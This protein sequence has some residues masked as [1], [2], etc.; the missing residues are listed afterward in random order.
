MSK[1]ISAKNISEAIGTLIAKLCYRAADE[2]GDGFAEKTSEWRSNNALEILKR[3]DNKYQKISISGN[4]HAHPRLVHHILEEGSWN[5]SDHVQNMWAGLLASSCTESGDDESNLVF[6]N[7]LKQLTSIEAVVV[8]Y[9]C[10]K[11]VKSITR[12]GWIW[13]E[14]LTIELEELVKLTGISDFHRLDR[15]LDHLRSLELIQGGFDPMSTAAN[16]TPSA[17]AIQMYVRCQGYIGSP[18]E[19]FGL[20]ENEDS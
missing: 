11:C 6:V 14:H 13:G 15:E 19:Y 2:L 17:L 8:N 20:N 7:I 16:I 12:A 9:A 4:E 1:E 18:I 10:E 5:E 3:A